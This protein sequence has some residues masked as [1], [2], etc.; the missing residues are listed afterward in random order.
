MSHG[1]KPEVE[2][3]FSAL[4]GQRMR[5]ERGGDQNAGEIPPWNI[6]Q[7]LNGILWGLHSN[8][9]QSLGGKSQA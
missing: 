8:M 1:K 5:N 3:A 6:M 7:P 9:E 4:V 2:M